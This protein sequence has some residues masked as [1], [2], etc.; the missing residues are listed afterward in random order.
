MA[1]R[2]LLNRC[3]LRPGE[4]LPSLFVRLQVANHYK[5]PK[6]IAAI[7]RLYVPPGD[8]I[9]LPRQA[10]SWQVLSELTRLP[11][12]VLYQATFHRCAA[13]L[14]L[15]WEPLESVTLP[16]GTEASLLSPRMQR[17]LLL[18]LSDTQYCPH[19]LAASR[20]HRLTWLHALAAVCLEHECLLQRGCPNCQSKLPVAAI[21]SGECP[22][23]RHDL[24]AS[25]A[26]P[27]GHDTWGLFT[28]HLLH[29]WW[30]NTP[31]PPCP[32]QVALP[33]QP[34]P[35]LLEV[36]QVLIPAAS[37]LPDEAAHPWPFA[38]QPLPPRRRAQSLP[39]QV[40][41]DGAT[42]MKALARW[43]Q[44][45]H[46]FLSDYRRRPGVPAGQVTEEFDPFYLNWLEEQWQR[47]E[48]AF[49]QAA[50]DDF[51]VANYP[52]SRS[53]TRLDRYQRSQALRDHFPYLTWAEA[54]QRLGAE[55]QLIQRL[56]EVGMLVDYE[57]GEGRQRPWHQRLRI[58]RRAEFVELQRRW[59]AGV[60]IADVARVL[61]MEVLVVAELVRAGM[62]VGGC[63]DS[64][65]VTMISL[66]T[67]AQKLPNNPA[68]PLD[69]S[70][71]ITLRQLVENGYDL[72]SI[73]RK[74]AGGDLKAV[75]L[76]GSLYD[77]RVSW[78]DLAS[79]EKGN[80]LPGRSPFSGR[81]S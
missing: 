71:A 72:V 50:F 4:S 39:A 37:R 31:P 15:P 11:A 55:P 26:V 64:E 22:G 40:Y 54:A 38:A 3:P 76:G 56:V 46:R 78:G 16:D 27:I 62:L 1:I 44:A 66:S 33:A 69:L 47:P 48:F 80:H 52:L 41:R 65:R 70:E 63:H 51:L 18:P 67:L 2:P 42:A 68:I 74:V 17:H 32:D 59:Q 13:A 61:G 25:P 58:V 30:D 20:Y 49:V 23:C 10:E 75:W 9:H 6:A 5:N 24:T 77:V 53:I 79:G 36:L 60:P 28:Q 29:S 81:H 8:N 12:L 34:V 35:I 14:A 73:L 21:V 7:G 57:T 45:F 43:P 19:C